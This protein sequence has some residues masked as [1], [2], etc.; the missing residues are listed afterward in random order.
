MTEQ[1]STHAQILIIALNGNG[2]NVPI[3]S[4]RMLWNSPQCYVAAWMEEEFGGE[5]IH[6]YVWLNPFAV[7]LKLSQNYLLISYTSKENKKFTI[8]KKKN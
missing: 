2:L 4:F 6:V 8:K 1:L 7:H 5:W 3:E